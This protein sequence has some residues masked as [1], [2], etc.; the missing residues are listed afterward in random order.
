M[1]RS[2]LP[3]LRENYPA[4]AKDLIGPLLDV[5]GAAREACGGD[6][7]KF[8]VMLVVATRTVED[9]RFAGLDLEEV[10]NGDLS[11]YPS[12][13]T[14]IRSIADSTGIPKET[15]RRKVAALV[16]QGWIRRVDHQLSLTPHA[17]RMLTAVRE[18]LLQLAAR[19]YG[20][21][22]SLQA[23]APSPR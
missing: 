4:I 9:R 8:Y 23:V 14:N 15:V 12:L 20:T 10:L 7:E 13:T 6:L 5:L 11:H 2:A 18:P 1:P 16:E 19:A 22:R 17:S 3:L 21:V